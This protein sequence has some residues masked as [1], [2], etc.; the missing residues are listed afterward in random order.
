MIPLFNKDGLVVLE[1]LSFTNTLYAFDFDGTLAK[2]VREPSSA[3]MNSETH[4]LM[5]QLSKLVPVAIISGR[6]V[7]DLKTSCI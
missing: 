3:K 6:S 1:S 5:A 2:I 4:N 7:Q